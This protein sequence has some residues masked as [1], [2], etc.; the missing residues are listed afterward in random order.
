ME[1]EN[2]ENRYEIFEEELKNLIEN[3]NNPGAICFALSQDNNL[4]TLSVY[5]QKSFFLSHGA[6]CSIKDVKMPYIKRVMNSI[7]IKKYGYIPVARTCDNFSIPHFP[8][9]GNI[10]C[11]SA[12]Y[13]RV[14]GHKNN[15]YHVSLMTP[16][17]IPRFVGA[18]E[19]R[20]LGRCKIVFDDDGYQA[21]IKFLESIGRY[22]IILK[23]EI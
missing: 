14:R 4:F 18:F 22:D 5:Y 11:F 7:C 20:G 15:V 19:K 1:K 12:E 16:E 3:D 2:T 8:H 9:S 13:R 17:A 10:I 6:I 23:M 21:F